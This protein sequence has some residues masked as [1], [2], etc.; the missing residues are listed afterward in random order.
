M[1]GDNKLA[2]DKTIRFVPAKSVLKYNIGDE[3]KLNESNFKALSA[4]FLA[5]ME[6]KHVAG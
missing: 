5:D 1:N 3:I 4:A 2:A 6:K